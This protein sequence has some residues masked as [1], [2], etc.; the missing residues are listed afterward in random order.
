MINPDWRHMAPRLAHEIRLNLS[1]RSVFDTFA[2][3]MNWYNGWLHKAVIGGLPL[4]SMGEART[5]SDEEIW[6]RVIV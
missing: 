3:P 4:L 1:T 2:G 5:L 6:D